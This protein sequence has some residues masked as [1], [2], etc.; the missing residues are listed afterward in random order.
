[1]RFNSN[2]EHPSAHPQHGCLVSKV[3]MMRRLVSTS[4]LIELAETSLLIELAETSL[5]IELAETSLLIE[6]AK[7]EFGR[8]F[9]ACH[10]LA[11]WR[12]VHGY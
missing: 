9:A 2:A 8:C 3:I 12:N 4:L 1:M 6:L 7:T 5:L 11:L 10:T